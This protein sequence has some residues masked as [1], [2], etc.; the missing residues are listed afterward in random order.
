ML[1]TSLVAFGLVLASGGVALAQPSSSDAG[2]T[3]MPPK[4]A[5]HHHHRPPPPGGPAALQGKGFDLQLGHGRGLRVQ[6]GDEPLK[7]CIQAAQPL[8]HMLSKS[9]S[10]RPG[11]IMKGPR[12]MMKGPGGMNGGSM[13]N[14]GTDNGQS[15]PPGDSGSSAPQP[16]PSDSDSSEKPGQM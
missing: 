15:K 14:S 8:V 1:K 3:H 16:S 11:G 4:P 9:M 12:G 13:P 10:H 6:C 5:G 2:P 7:G